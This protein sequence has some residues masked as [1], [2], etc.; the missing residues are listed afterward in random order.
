MCGGRGDMEYGEHV[1]K[2]FFLNL[3]L[4]VKHTTDIVT[5]GECVYR[6]KVRLGLYGI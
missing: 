6:I 5:T 4:T 3:I 2:I 1:P